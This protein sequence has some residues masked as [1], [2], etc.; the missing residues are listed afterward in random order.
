MLLSL[1]LLIGAAAATTACE[2]VTV[3]YQ[4]NGNWSSH[5]DQPSALF[6]NQPSTYDEAA[7]TCADHNETLLS[8][9]QFAD[10]YNQFTYQ[11]Y[12]GKIDTDV[13]LWSSCNSSL[14][15]SWTGSVSS[16]NT[17]SGSFPFLCTN[18]A[19]FVSKVDTD[20]SV[21]PRVNTTV[22]GTTFEGL[23][24]HMAFRFMGIPYAKPPVGDL[25]FKYAESWNSSY[26]NATKYSA[27]CLQYGWFDGNS[28]GLNPWG[29]SEDCLYLN[30]FTS[31]IPADPPIID[32]ASLKPVMF[33][34]HGGAQTSGTGTD[35]TFDGD[36]LVSRSD[37]VLVTINYRLN[38][39]G[40]LSLND[41]VVPGN[42]ALTDKIAALEW[43]QKY[44]SGFGGNPNN[45]TIFGQSAGGGSVIDLITSPKAS[46]LYE[47]AILQSS[48]RGHDT[49]PSV[50]AAA[51]LPYLDQYCNGAGEERLECL[52][53]LPAET[54][55]NIT[56]SEVATWQTVVDG[57]YVP[58]IPI[59][60]V[61]KG[62]PY[63]NTVKYLSGFM[64]EEAQSLLQTTLAP[65]MTDFNETMQILVEAGQL[66]QAQADAVF[67]S[68][69]WLVTNET[70]NNASS[71]YTNVYN[72][73]I[74]VATDATISCF[75]VGFTIVGAAVSAWESMWIYEHQR[76]YGLSFYDFYDLCT[77][78]DGEP[79]TPYYRCHSSD[80]YEVFGTYYLFDLPV[81]VADDIYY[82][83][84]VQDMWASF[85]RTGNP[86]VDQ[87]YLT[88][89][90]YNSTLAFFS[91][92]QWP[93]FNS[94]DPQVA[95][96]QYP[97]PGYKALPDLEHCKVL[98]PYAT[99]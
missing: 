43:V 94:W 66:V 96:L 21:F 51:V 58:D 95:S 76:G 75:G 29:N 12:L 82:T 1:Y 55:L 86:N 46:G 28:Y 39:F 11:Q 64:P 2:G 42:Y 30:V 81:R 40:Y 23:R 99:L 5:A 18:S 36:S 50:A 63:I 53:A 79:D 49:N 80:L 19:P 7:A 47:G 87:D 72:A 35:S 8:C 78:P 17:S 92:W 41:S 65:N 60:Q 73:S 9:D 20:Y 52:Q 88:A 70:V 6:V 67:A 37:I 44:I 22:N 98:M 84:A 31:S 16:S 24:D 93:E 34:M 89:R 38:I 56:Y 33:W 4:N 27:A 90:G 57:I 71:T 26:V 25:R 10:F 97:T 91:N 45:V 15:S 83:N 59:S 69:L 68:N 3:F 14:P 48:G 13:L 32:T 54:L 77:F 85:A 74:N 62:R 61:A